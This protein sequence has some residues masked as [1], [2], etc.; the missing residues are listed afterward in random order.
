MVYESQILIPLTVKSALVA[1]VPKLEDVPEDEKD[2]HPR[3]NHQ[4]FDLV[5]RSLSCR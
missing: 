4:V 1:A 2:C 5:H 3:S